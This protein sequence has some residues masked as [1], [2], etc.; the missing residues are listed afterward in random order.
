MTKPTLTLFAFLMLSMAATAHFY[1]SAGAGYALA[2]AGGTN[3]GIANYNGSQI[4]S[5]NGASPSTFSVNQAS[6][7][8]GVSGALGA[9]YFLNKHFGIQLNGNM[10]L[11]NKK[12]TFSENYS[13]SGGVVYPYVITLTRQAKNFLL[14]IPSMVVC[15]DAE[16]L[17]AYC[18]FGVALPV[19]S[20]ITREETIN[21]SSSSGNREEYIKFTEKN[22]FS[23][24]ISAAAGIKYKLS[25]KVNIWAE[26]NSLSMSLYIKEADPGNLSVNGVPD[27]TRQQ[28]THFSK[29]GNYSNSTSQSAMPAYLQPFS[30]IGISAGV[31]FEL[32]RADKSER[33]YQGKKAGI[34]YEE[35]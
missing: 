23:L 24:G 32:N 3:S 13:Q 10:G 6:F 5:P 8:A 18:R 35:K 33:I 1:I 28:V 2:M 12:Y 11:V 4:L 25:E 31:S 16:K 15:T 21:A 9:G 19:M 20:Q 29:N 26:I 22:S 27:T 17:N 14:L 7:S 30:N 34:E